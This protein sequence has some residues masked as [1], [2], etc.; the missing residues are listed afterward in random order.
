MPCPI[1]DADE[2]WPIPFARDPKVERWRREAGDDASYEWRLCRRCANAYPSHQP[3]LRLLQKIWLEHKSTPGLSMAELE[4][5][6]A[7]RRV[8][9]RK[10]AAR[11]LRIFAPL[12][13]TGGRRFLDIACG[14]GET[15]KT[16]A[17]HGWDAEGIDADSSIADVH[18]S[19]GIRVRHGQIEDMDVGAGYDIIH[20]AHAIYFITNP[21][22]FLSE[23]RKRLA[24]DGL[25]CIVLS[26]FFAH[27]DPGL[28]SYAHTFFPSGGSMRYALALAGF[29]TVRCKRISG[30]IYIAARPAPAPKT[31]HIS[32]R[33][34]RFLFR[35]KAQR[36]A[37]IG[38][39]Y[40][41]LRRAA[42]LL[43]GRK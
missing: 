18:R 26:D 34:T 39:P 3:H 43:L 24:A 28:P 9:T 6:W 36:Y 14:F 42:K 31:P 5:A 22:K 41:G 17:D 23:V 25:F 27:H 21:M 15:V 8:G 20:I 12:A 29:E 35:T 40:L 33:R 38:R 10:L 37:L 7:R 2:C 16:F 30:S 1:C 19:M 13:K 4:D 32:P 11:S